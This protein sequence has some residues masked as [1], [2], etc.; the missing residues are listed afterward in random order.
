MRALALQSNE[1]AT[2]LKKRGPQAHTVPVSPLFS[3]SAS[4]N[5]GMI[6]RKEGCACGGDCPTCQ[7]KE[8]PELQTKLKLGH[9][10]DPAERE[11]DAVAENVMRMP[12]PPQNAGAER[13]ISRIFGASQ[14]PRVSR[15]ALP[16]S[17]SYAKNGLSTVDRVLR[18][19]GEPLETSARAF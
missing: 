11:A 12:A 4:L 18:S 13:N 1:A 19:A 14:T 6:Q 8:R 17:R 16:A 7:E 3:Q 10:A 9:I 5:F 2:P 15:H